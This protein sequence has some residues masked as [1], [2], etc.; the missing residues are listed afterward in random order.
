MAR[1]NWTI[2][3]NVDIIETA[4]KQVIAVSR[5]SWVED[6]SIS[7]YVFHVEKC[8]RFAGTDRPDKVLQRLIGKKY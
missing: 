2:K 5:R 1:I 6:H 8:L 7:R 3:G 4:S